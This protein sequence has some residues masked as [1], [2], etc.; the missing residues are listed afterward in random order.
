MGS[1]EKDIPSS[2]NI[3]GKQCIVYKGSPANRQHS[4][5]FVR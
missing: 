5:T 3:A 2:I 1:E 4:V